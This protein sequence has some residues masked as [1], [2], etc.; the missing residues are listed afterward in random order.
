MQTG[1]STNCTLVL[2]APHPPFA[3][4]DDATRRRRRRTTCPSND[5]QPVAA[6]CSAAHRDRVDHGAVS[7]GEL[8]KAYLQADSGGVPQ[9]SFFVVFTRS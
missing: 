3:I 7:R 1:V 4:R 9:Y 2:R 5:A 8:A 6:A